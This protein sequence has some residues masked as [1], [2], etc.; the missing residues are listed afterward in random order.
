M[1]DPVTITE[2]LTTGFS[3]AEAQERLAAHF[4][5][6]I[7][8]NTPGTLVATSGSK[9]A[10]RLLGAYLMPKAWMPAKTTVGFAPSGRGCQVTVTCTDNFGFGIRAGMRRR[11]QGLLQTKLEEIRQLLPA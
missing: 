7:V 2:T 11:Y 1:T 8:T 4:A 5:S 10:I 3:P 6:R 9:V